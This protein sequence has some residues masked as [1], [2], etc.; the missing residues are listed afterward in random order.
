MT[1]PHENGYAAKAN[2]YLWWDFV[3]FIQFV[4]NHILMP[5]F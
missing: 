4:V 2:A 5:V 3:Y 1:A